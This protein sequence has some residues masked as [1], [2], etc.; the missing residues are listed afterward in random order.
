[1]VYGGMKNHSYFDFESL[2]ISDDRL[3][4]RLGK[5]M[6]K[7]E[8]DPGSSFPN[9]FENPSD[10]TAFYRL[11]NN[12]KMEYLSLFENS[13]RETQRH[14]LSEEAVIL[15]HDTST[16]TL[17]DGDSP[18]IRG[19][20]RLSGKKRGFF[21]HFCLAITPEREALGLIGFKAYTRG[22]NVL[23]YRSRV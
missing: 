14:A 16:F 11:M 10:L 7:I 12:E 23:N 6:A 19:L 21:G 5:V 8:E 17:D 13:F 22:K 2:E 15:I 1:M 3:R 18:H 4:Q 20:G 9:I